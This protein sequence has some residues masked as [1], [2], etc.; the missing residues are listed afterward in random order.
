MI[1][2]TFRPADSNDRQALKSV[3][4]IV[5]VLD[6]NFP[7]FHLTKGIN[8]EVGRALNRLGY[9]PHKTASCQKYDIEFMSKLPE[10]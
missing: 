7:N 3:D 8:A 6:K 10:K 9:E 1:S 5:E 4:E 2:L